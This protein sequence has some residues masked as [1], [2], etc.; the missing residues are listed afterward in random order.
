MKISLS[1]HGHTYEVQQPPHDI[2]IPMHFGGPQPSSYGLPPAKAEAYRDGNWV[3]DVNEGGSCNFFIITFT[4]HC[5]GTHTESVGH[6]ADES[7]PIHKVLHES[8]IPATLG[9]VIPERAADSDESYDPV[10]GPE[11]L[12]ITKKS[13][14]AALLDHNPEFLKGLVLRTLPNPEAKKSWD[15]SEVLPPYFSL[16]GMQ[17]IHDLGVMHLLVDIPSVDRLFDEGKLRNHRIFW[18]LNE[19]GHAADLSNTFTQHR[20]ITEFIYAPDTIDNGYYLLD[21]QIAPFMSDA[22]PSRPRLYPVHLV[23]GQ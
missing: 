17:Y 8:L 7:I 22:S 1:V 10:A 13:L 11:D 20:T 14:E 12:L 19:Q 5:N 4:P 2:S 16:E 15:Y 18:Q 6:L 21:L 3:G 9:T 23:D